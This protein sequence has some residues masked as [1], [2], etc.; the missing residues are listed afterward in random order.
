[1]ELQE[2]KPDGIYFEGFFG[3][4]LKDYPAWRYH[5]FLE[6][7]I[8]KDAQEDERARLEGWE[9]MSAP[10]S[11]NT[12]LI[13]WFWDLEDMSAKQ[14]CVYAREEFDVDFPQDAG[15]EKL[16]KAVLELGK[17]APQNRNRLVLMAH[18]IRMNYEE[19]LFEIRRMASGGSSHMETQV[20]EI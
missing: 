20:I 4:T 14:L 19:T 15:Q 9:P 8:V 2:R 6:P 7:R 17:H 18:T 13:N 1:M 16:L 3:K 11:A 5:K 10:M 12:G